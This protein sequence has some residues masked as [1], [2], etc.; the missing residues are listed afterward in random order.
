MTYGLNMA[1]LDLGLALH[2]DL[3]AVWVDVAITGRT[4]IANQ[5]FPSHRRQTLP[6]SRRESQYLFLKV[7]ERGHRISYSASGTRFR[8][9]PVVEFSQCYGRH[10]YHINGQAPRTAGSAA[11]IAMTMLVSSRNLP[12][13]RIDH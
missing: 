1:R 6:L 5:A 10:E 4:A 2:G 12:F 3:Y 11:K 8:D 9:S 13:T 7:N